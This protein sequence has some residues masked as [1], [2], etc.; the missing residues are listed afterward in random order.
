MLGEEAEFVE[1]RKYVIVSD[2][3]YFAKS[4][5][6]IHC[7]MYSSDVIPVQLDYFGRDL[8]FAKCTCMFSTRKRI[9]SLVCIAK[10]H[11]IEYN[12]LKSSG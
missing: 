6:K 2:S 1:G 5:I 11:T 3:E 4:V 12:F 9:L 10:S 8:V 7:C